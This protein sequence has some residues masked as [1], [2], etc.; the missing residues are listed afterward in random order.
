[1]AEHDF[2]NFSQ[3]RSFLYETSDA[4]FFISSMFDRHIADILGPRVCR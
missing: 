3:M 4:E 1:M 2:N